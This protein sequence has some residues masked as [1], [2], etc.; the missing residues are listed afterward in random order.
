MVSMTFVQ[1]S[2]KVDFRRFATSTYPLYTMPLKAAICA[3]P[4]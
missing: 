3:M 4:L 2:S 1:G